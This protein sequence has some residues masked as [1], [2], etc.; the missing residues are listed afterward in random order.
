MNVRE[1]IEALVEIEGRGPGSDAERRAAE[2]LVGR[3]EQL[4]RG[5]NTEAVDVWP[6]WPAT[7]ALHATLAI[8][9]SVV[10]VSI[11]ILGAALVLVATVLT[12]LDAN[13]M[14]L[15]TRKLL[16]KRASQN[17]ISRERNDNG[18]V[19][20]L[21]AHYD[22]GKGGLAYNRKL[23]ER[24]ASLSKSLKRPIGPI[25]PLFYAMVFV[26][27]FAFVRLVGIDSMILTVFQFLGTVALIMSLPLLIDTA[28]ADTVPGANDNAS[29]VATVLRLAERYGGEL[30][31]F[32]VHV[33]FTGSEEAFALGMRSYLK[34]HKQDLNP[35]R[36]V[37]LNLE[38][39]GAGTVRFTTKE[40]LLAPLASHSQL[41]SFCKEIVEAREQAE[42]SAREDDEDEDGDDDR[43]DE[44][45]EDE[46]GEN[47]DDEDT[48]ERVG[49][50]GFVSRTVSD[51][52]AARSAG[53]PA[54]TITC[55][56][57]LDYTAT[58]HQ[59]ADTADRI[60][61]DALERAYA[62]SCELIEKL[63]QTVGPDLEKPVEGTMLK[64]EDE[65]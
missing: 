41:V 55:K 1:E 4:G 32:D 60:D 11:P 15:T 39:V 65:D 51:G 12:F 34:R 29:G 3:L 54:I 38:E 59:L 2:H 22:A 10:S 16:G 13:G 63:D 36:I 40:G 53:F 31:Y 28:L 45:K 17:V 8:A 44:L 25:Q 19:L 50:R 24:R 61:D 62:F 27:V 46:D 48:A 52:Y 6:N 57:R 42:E 35:E 26:L 7:Y 37:F 47:E 58:H 43:P 18:G 5:A 49:V 56:G 33:L 23:H 30:E 20:V 9:G 64:E 21:V 14:A